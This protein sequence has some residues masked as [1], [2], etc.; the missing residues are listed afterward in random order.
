MVAVAF[1]SGSLLPGG[2]IGVDVF[3]AFSGFVITA[4][5]HREWLESGT[6]RLG[7]F[8]FWRF[9]RLIPALS[10]VAT[11]NVVAE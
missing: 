11:F 6:I 1:H 5:L 8:Y 4:T 2:F 7:T 9:K 3:F 10:L